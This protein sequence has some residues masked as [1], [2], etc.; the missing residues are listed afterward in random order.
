M[1]TAISNCYYK[2][3]LE[4]DFPQSFSKHWSF[5]LLCYPELFVFPAE[6]TFY[7]KYIV[8]FLQRFYFF[9]TKNCRFIKKNVCFTTKIHKYVVFLWK[10]EVKIVLLL[11]T[12][13]FK[14]TFRLL[15]KKLFTSNL[16]QRS[17]SD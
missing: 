3:F 1:I 17:C 8:F 11:K 2:F 16:N 5:K 13:L 7:H 6:K 10:D 15:I 14:I 9:S 12:I 4:M